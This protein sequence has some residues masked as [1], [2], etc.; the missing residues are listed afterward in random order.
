MRVVLQ[1]T[2]GATVTI[3]GEI[4]G[5]IGKGLVVLLGIEEADEQADADWLCAKLSAL[6]IFSDDAGKMNLCITEVGGAFLVVSQFT[7]HASYKKGN[8]PSFIRAAAPEKAI[9]LYEYFIRKL[10]QT[11]GC[12]VETGV[13]GAMMEV[14]LVNNGPVTITMDSKDKE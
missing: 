13:F 2:S 4:S 6:R 12:P 14:S 3:D 1:R 8:R 11:S 5:K 7:L 10:H 9:P